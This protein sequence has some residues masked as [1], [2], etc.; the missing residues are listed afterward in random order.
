L[1]GGL[2]IVGH[3]SVPLLHLV[4]ESYLRVPKG[5]ASPTRFLLAMFQSKNRP[6]QVECDS[7]SKITL[8]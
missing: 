2:I 1:E 5:S 4:H 8:Y 6:I 7:L 3:M